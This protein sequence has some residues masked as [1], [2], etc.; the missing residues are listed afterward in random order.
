MGEMNTAA[1]SS[2]ELLLVIAS[3][4]VLGIIGGWISGKLKLPDVV[5][6]LLCGVAFGPT[7]LNIVN[8][9]AFPTANEL[10]LTFGSAFILYE[11]GSEIKVRVLNEVKI[12]VGILASIGVFITAGIIGISCYYI[13]G[14]PIGV[15]LLTGSIISS[16]DPASLVPVFKQVKIK[17]KLKQTIISESAFN[18][19][20]GAILFTSVLTG[21]TLTEKVG[22]I[23]TSFQLV[24]MIVVGVLVGTGIALIGIGLSSERKI[25]IFRNYAPI[26]SLVMV[27][28]SYEISE[29]FGGS[30]Y[31]SVFICGLIYG[32]KRRF[33]LWVPDENYVPTLHFRENI[34]TIAR[35]SI[36][37][38]LGTHLDLNALV[39]YG[40]NALLVV[41]ILIF[42]ARPIVVIIATSLDIKA[43]W[44]KKEKIFMMWIRETGVIPAALSGI[45]VS[46]KV[47]GYEVVSSVVFMTIVVTLLVQASTTGIVAKKLDVLEE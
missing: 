35:M 11:G 28:F 33:G 47:P 31:M 41:L 18:D 19:A 10:I 13:L 20:F 16:T 14:L 24:F 26:I 40:P 27:I 7:F 38:I 1:V 46:T 12:T 6:Y 2:N 32:N 42:I 43:N 8:I 36:F 21:I 4:S 9:D 34:A 3:V 30:G 15:S 45:V 5:I 17:D 25:G 44:Q 37:I 29:R 39:K 23:R 22:V